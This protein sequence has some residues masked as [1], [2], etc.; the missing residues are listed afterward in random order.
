MRGSLMGKRSN[1][2][3]R[4]VIGGDPNLDLDQLGVPIRMA[5]RLTIPEK[6]TSFNIY[7]MTERVRKGPTHRKGA[8]YVTTK[9]GER[10]DLTLAKMASLSIGDTVE[11]PLQDNDLVAF[12]RQPSLHKGSM[13]AFRVKLMPHNTFRMPLSVTPSFNAGE[14]CQCR[15]FK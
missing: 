2:T 15:D 6:V 12:N 3:A 4:T 5:S 9:G 14:L 1:F 10:F 8:R 7:Q 11:R 13:M